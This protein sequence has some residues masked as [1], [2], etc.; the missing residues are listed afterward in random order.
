MPKAKYTVFT[1]V[2]FSSSTFVDASAILFASSAQR[3]YSI[4]RSMERH[5]FWPFRPFPPFLP[6]RTNF[7]SANNRLL[8][9]AWRPP[10]WISF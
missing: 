9:F 10:F 3:L 2:F 5:P 4:D 7:T 8:G 1:A 6:F